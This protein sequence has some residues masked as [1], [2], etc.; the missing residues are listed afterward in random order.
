MAEIILADLVHPNCSQYWRCLEERVDK[1]LSSLGNDTS[2]PVYLILQQHADCAEETTET[3]LLGKCVGLNRPVHVLTDSS[4]VAVLYAF[5]RAADA[6]DVRHVHVMT[7]SARRVELQECEKQLFT[8]VYTFTYSCMLDCSSCPLTQLN[9]TRFQLK[10]QISAFLQRLPALRG[11][12]T[13]L[14]TSLI[15]G[16]FHWIK[17]HCR[18]GGVPS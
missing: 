10:E 17:E 9:T 15:S 4:S 13:V 6:L 1:L 3:S 18:A 8:D 7:C 11:E 14:K 12:I 2:E 5:K 16:T